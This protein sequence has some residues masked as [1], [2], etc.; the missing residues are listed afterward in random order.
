MTDVYVY[1]DYA[2]HQH[3][4]VADDAVVVAAAVAAARAVDAESSG[5]M[6]DNDGEGKARTKWNGRTRRR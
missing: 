4:A 3:A 2:E 1:R 6:R 5:A